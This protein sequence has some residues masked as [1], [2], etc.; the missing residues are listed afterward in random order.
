MQERMGLFL[1]L[2]FL[3]V[4]GERLWMELR[5]ILCGRFNEPIMQTMLKLGIGQY[6]GRKF[7]QRFVSGYL[8][9]QFSRVITQTDLFS[10]A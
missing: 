1:F 7:G 4:S 3:G 2:F 10:G 8:S 5:K 6:I 9:K